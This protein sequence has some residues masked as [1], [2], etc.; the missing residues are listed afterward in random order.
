VFGLV[1]AIRAARLDLQ[2]TL[3]DS[4]RDARAGSRERLRGTLVVSELCLAQVLLVGAGLLIRSAI[5]TQAVPV[6]FDTRNLLT[7]SIGLPRARYSNEERVEAAFQE[8]ERAIGAVPGVKSVGRAQVVPIA[9]WGWDW[10]A[11]REGSDG[12]DDGAVDS[13]MRFVSPNYFATLGLR[14]LRGRAFTPADG[15][16]GLHV[17]IVSRGLAKRLYGDADPIGRRVSNSGGKDWLE[18]VGVVDDMHA[19]GLKQEPPRELYMPTTQRGN[20]SY[21]LLV[22]GSVP[23]TTLTPAIRRAIATVDP[24]LAISAIGTMEQA[25]DKSLAMDR[26]TKWLFTLLGATGLV[27]A[28]VGVYG[29]IAYFVTQRTHELGVRL[30]LGASASGLRWLVVKQGLL[31]ASLGVTIGAVVSL[32]VSRLLSSM[33]FGVTP[34]DPMTFIGVSVV[35]AAV[36][37]GASYL[38]ARRATRI[39]PLEAL[40]S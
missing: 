33:L 35:L 14:L 11:Q 27:L 19:S 32:G 38:P 8:M 20:P 34:R 26:F 25:V 18:I 4:T 1:P 16:Q 13:D 40:R 37:V 6:G 12:H 30:A 24:L 28:I 17:A 15:P 7:V 36:A 9:G 23:V 5:V 39:D 29:V 31:L 22:R 3:R 2:Q 21:T 10:T